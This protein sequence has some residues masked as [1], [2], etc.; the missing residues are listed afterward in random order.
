MKTV[1]VTRR[2]KKLQKIRNVL[3]RIAAFVLG[4]VIVVMA[5]AFAV[6]QFGMQTVIID[7]SM[8]DTLQS[9]D[10]VL[11]N[12]LAY[13]TGNPDRMDIAVVRVG[14]SEFS[15]SYVRRVIGLPGETVR[16]TDGIL[17]IND[18]AVD[19]PFNESPI[20]NGGAAKEGITLGDD[21][22]FVLCDNYNNSRDDS[23]LDSI[24]LIDEDQMS[25]KVWMTLFPLSHLSF[26]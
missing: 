22:Y 5:A 2:K 10:V 15:P 14:S 21:Q 24:G 23:R 6:R 8:S 11:I 19:I 25:G 1:S 16:I 9:E 17:Y 18:E 3:I 20:E 12:K 13:I 7:Q 26:E 4:I